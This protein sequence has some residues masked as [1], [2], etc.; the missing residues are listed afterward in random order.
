M[1]LFLDA[2]RRALEIE[3]SGADLADA[4]ADVR[5]LV[6][7]FRDDPP[8]PAEPAVLADNA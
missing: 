3:V 7:T 8:L 2:E 6:R 1:F 5:S 4:V